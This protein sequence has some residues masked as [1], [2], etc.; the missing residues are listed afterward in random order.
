MSVASKALA[1]VGKAKNSGYCETFT[2]SCFGFAAK[3]GS[4]R[5]AYLAS[6]AAGKIHTDTSP[7]PGV[8][9]FW[10][11]TYGTNAPYDHVA[12]SVGGG[13]CVSTS[14]GPGRTVAKVRISDLT[15]RWGMTYRGWGEWYH[16]V[17]VYTPPKKPAK[18][19]P[20]ADLKTTDSRYD[21][22]ATLLASVGYKDKSVVLRQQRWLKDRGYYKGR[23]DGKWGEMSTEALQSFLYDKGL[24]RNGSHPKS[25]LV[26]GEFGARTLAAEVAYLN[27]QRHYLI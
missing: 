13:Y 9:V 8:P 6:K 22:W 16:G 12:V 17:R 15:K 11:I 19:W 20:H 14:A 25:V 10:D 4:A 1:A 7:P 21:A 24:Y 5:L 26:D 2:R 23:L 18:K 27:Q 3:Y